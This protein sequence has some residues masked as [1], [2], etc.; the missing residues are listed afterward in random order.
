MTPSS[1]KTA[2]KLTQFLT[3]AFFFWEKMAFELGVCYL[4]QHIQS[5]CLCFVCICSNH[6]GKDLVAPSERS[7]LGGYQTFTDRA[8]TNTKRAKSAL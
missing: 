3:L 8:A 6:I 7:E 5:E 2:P 4:H 1:E